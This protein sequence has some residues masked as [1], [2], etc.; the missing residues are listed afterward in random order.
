MDRVERV[1]AEQF[2]FEYLGKQATPPNGKKFQFI[3]LGKYMVSG[4]LVA[5][6]VLN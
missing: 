3:Y 4:S 5:N 1:A 2:L 6:N